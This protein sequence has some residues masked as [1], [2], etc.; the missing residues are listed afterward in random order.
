MTLCEICEQEITMG[1][2]DHGR[3]GCETE[4]P[5]GCHGDLTKCVYAHGVN[6]GVNKE[7]HIITKKS[8]VIQ[9]Y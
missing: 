6:H 2:D 8:R 1:D 4:C 5:C 7:S 9:I 3:C